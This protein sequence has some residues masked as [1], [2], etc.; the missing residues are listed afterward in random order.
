MWQ[1]YEK[2]FIPA[3]AFRPRTKILQIL[4]QILHILKVAALNLTIIKP[5]LTDLQP[6]L[7]PPNDVPS[8]E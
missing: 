3:I 5:Q 7:S 6:P 2:N 8:A 4:K 1:S